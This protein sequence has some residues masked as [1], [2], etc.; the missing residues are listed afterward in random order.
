MLALINMFTRHRHVLPHNKK[1]QAPDRVIFFDTETV[2]IP[3]DRKTRD[4]ALK[5][6]HAIYTRRS[7]S[8]TYDTEDHLS[9]KTC[10]DFCAWIEHVCQG[11]ERFTIVAHNVTFDLRIT[12]LTRHLMRVGWTRTN[13]T[14]KGINFMATYQ[15]PV[16]GHVCSRKCFPSI[17]GMKH[18]GPKT[19]IFIMDNMQ[20]F[21]TSLAKLGESIGVPKH[22]VDFS[23]VTEDEL[24]HYCIQ[25]VEVIRQAWNTW[26]R[27]LQD[28][29][30]G[31]FQRS[32]ASQ[33][34][35]SFRHRFMDTPVEIHTNEKAIA[36]ERASYHGGRVE[37]FTIGHF[38]E[39]PY[40]ALDV[41]SMYPAVM[42]SL[43]VPVRFISQSK[44]AT[45]DDLAWAHKES[46]YIVEATVTMRKPVLPAIVG[47]R[48]VFPIGTFKGTFTKPEL[49][50]AM[51]WGKI[52]ELGAIA[53]YEERIVFRSFVDFFYNARKRFSV[54]GRPEFA[55]FSKLI[56]NSLYGKFGQQTTDFRAAGY[57]PDLPDEAGETYSLFDGKTVKY[58]RLDG[59]TEI[60]TGTREAYNAFPAIAS[61]ITAAARV[62]LHK[63]IM[64]A[65]EENVLYCDTDSLF[66][67]SEGYSKLSASMNA[68]ELGKLKLEG[69]ADEITIRG[70]KR[71]IFG[72]KER[73]KGIRKDAVKVRDGVYVQDQFEGF[74]GA[75]RKARTD[76][77]RITRVTKRL[78]DDYKKGK[79]T[80]SGR[81][82][83]LAVR[84]EQAVEIVARKRPLS[85]RPRRSRS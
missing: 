61:Y 46:G 40:Y 41:N 53:I 50:Y 80:A 20:L 29:D 59:L 54:E 4:L 2:E 1:R 49:E 12:G 39:G 62:S 52:E 82:Q 6:G 22:D 74:A 45:L 67:N 66:V 47:K 35:S 81:V 69:T 8:G 27:Y 51:R 60:E 7:P 34:L 85:R 48:L 21:P 78:K 10:V 9:F 18:H 26:Y 37:C 71:Y 38:S 16:A 56:L 33:A 31:N 75:L 11:P 28:N 13:L 68:H 24:L 36:L 77:V 83:P 57:N 79:V 30:L 76:T 73:N 55:H 42:R 63:F 43:A 72:S 14:M 58:R 15:K 25:D 23:T 84:L 64:I 32:L 3:V 19:T 65:R 44:K 5:L 17:A 70:P